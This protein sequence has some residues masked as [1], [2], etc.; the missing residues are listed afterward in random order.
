MN[1]TITLVAGGT[2]QAAGGFYL[3][4]SADRELLEL[5]RKGRFTYILTSRQMGKSSLMIRTAEKLQAEGIRIVIIDLTELGTDL[6]SDQ[7]YRGILFNISD[8]LGLRTDLASWW[9]LKGD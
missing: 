9:K 7:W 5:C 8:Q 3:E 1:P 2:V 6:T 4:R